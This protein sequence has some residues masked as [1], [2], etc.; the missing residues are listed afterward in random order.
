MHFATRSPRCSRETVAI[1][2][3]TTVGIRPASAVY[4]G[5]LEDGDHEGSGE[6]AASPGGVDRAAGREADDA[7]A[8]HRGSLALGPGRAADR[9]R[10]PGRARPDAWSPGR[11]MARLHRGDV[12]PAVDS[13][14]PAGSSQSPTATADRREQ[15]SPADRPGIGSGRPGRLRRLGPARRIARPDHGARLESRRPA[16]AFGRVVAEADGRGR[17]EVV[18]PGRAGPRGD[19][20]SQ[21]VDDP[22]PRRARLPG[23]GDRLEPRRPIPGRPPAQARSAW[24]SSGPTT[25]GRSSRSTTASSR[26]GRPTGD[27]AFYSSSG[28]GPTR[29]NASIARSAS[30][31]CWPRSARRAGPAPGPATACRSLFVAR[32]SVLEAASRPAIRSSCSGSGSTIRPGSSDAGRRRSRSLGRDRAVEGVSLARTA[33]ARTSSLAIVEGPAVPDR[34]VSPSRAERSTSCSRSSTRCSPRG[35]VA[36]A[37]RPDPGRSGSATDDRLGAAVL[38]D[39][40]TRGVLDAAR[41]RRSAADRVDRDPGPGPSVLSSCRRPP[42][43]PNVAGRAIE[44]PSLLPILGEFEANSERPCPAPP[45]RPDRPPALRRPADAPPAD[46]T[47]ARSTRPGSSSITSART[48][49]PPSTSLEA[50]TRSSRPPD[51]RLAV[52]GVRG[53]IFIGQGNVDR[54]E[55]TIAFLRAA[56][57]K[58]ARTD[59]VDGDRLYPDRPSS[60][61]RPARA[62]PI[63]CAWPGASVRAMLHEDAPEG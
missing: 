47:S 36:L 12:R 9:D 30:R 62:G 23:P 34:L 48:I 52:L 27:L 11:Q 29:S 59:R 15:Q 17:F 43:G 7:D 39:L 24:R 53:Q 10:R 45:A 37:R 2:R 41:A 21:P 61:R 20:L 60:R 54:A 19:R 33:T 42:R 57:A 8:A 51:R 31:G 50:S 28:T 40:E 49:P 22:A 32:R 35:L 63:T 4:L 38:C 25:A 56:R 14:S 44:R 55:Q 58:P 18:D 1:S 3:R 26:P 16:L 5:E 13:S 46:P 6:P